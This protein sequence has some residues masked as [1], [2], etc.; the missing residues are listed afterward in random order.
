MRR[1][2]ALSIL[3]LPLLIACGS[4]DDKEAEPAE[5]VD[6]EKTVSLKKSWSRSIGNGQSRLYNRIQPHIFG[7]HLYV[8]AANGEV[9]KLSADSGKTV[10]R[11]TLKEDL[12]AGIGVGCDAL[13]V[14]NTSGEVIALN[15]QNGEQLWRVA[16]G[17]EVLAAPQCDNGLVAVQTFDGRLLGLNAADGSKRWTY[18]AIVP[19]LTLRGTSTPFFYEDLVISGFANGKLVAIT[20]DGGAVR[21]ESRI[22]IA[23]GSSEI[24]RIADVDAPLYV[25]LQFLYA[26]GYQGNLA[27]IDPSNGRRL[28]LREASSTNA[29]SE[30]FSNIYV[31]AANG[32]LQAFSKKGQGLV[33]EQDMLARRQLSATQTIGSYVAVGDYKGYIHLFSQVDGEPVGRLRPTSSAIRVAMLNY[34]DT[35]IS[36]NNDGTLSAYRLP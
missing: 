4:S 34:N 2:V 29:L 24:E 30:G 3:L 13:F 21:W 19:V 25:D 33:W 12:S 16:A 11:N 17:A 32:N 26:I 36:Y 14:A 22:S 18:N 5:L 7:E 23:Q 28:W 8:A 35:L 15:E 20:T 9:Y 10:W 27:A 31:A 1:F 6:F